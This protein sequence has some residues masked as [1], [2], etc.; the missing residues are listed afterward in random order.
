MRTH[1]ERLSDCQLYYIHIIGM[2][3]YRIQNQKRNENFQQLSTK[4]MQKNFK[5]PFFSSV[6]NPTTTEKIRNAFQSY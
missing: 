5:F 6:L 4:K 3:F 1:S 2:I